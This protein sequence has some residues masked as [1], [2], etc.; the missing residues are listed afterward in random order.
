MAKIGEKW[1]WPQNISKLG[2]FAEEVR[3]PN[4]EVNP[5]AAPMPL[6]APTAFL[7]PVRS[8]E[9]LRVGEPPAFSADPAE[10]EAVALRHVLFRR[11]LSRR[12]DP[13]LQ[14]VEAAVE[15]NPLDGLPASRRDQMRA[16]LRRERAMLDILARYNGLAEEVY[17]HM[18]SEAKG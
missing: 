1:P 13:R 16:S 17:A 9:S 5:E 8:S 15:Q 10:V 11:V 4:L 7:A 6:A 12:S 3:R 14:A 18:L 2:T